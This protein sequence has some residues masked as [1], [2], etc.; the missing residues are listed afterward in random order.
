[1]SRQSLIF[2]RALNNTILS[3]DDIARRAPAVFADSK[4]QRLTS[5]YQSLRTDT[6]LPILADYGYQPTQAA[7]KR[8]RKIAGLD[9]HSAHLLA[10][11]KTS[12]IYTND[13]IR[14]EIVLY[15]SH[16]GT[17]SV[18]LYAGAYRFICSNGIVAGDGFS[19]TAYHSRKALSGFEEMLRGVIANMPKLLD[20]IDTMRQQSLDYD[21]RYALA[22]QAVMKRWQLLDDAAVEA[23]QRGGNVKRGSYADNHTINDVLGMQRAE[24]AG[25][26][27]WTTFNRIQENVL[28]G[29][30]F[31]RSVVGDDNE[32]VVRQ[33]KARPIT[34]ISE[35]V[36]INSELWDIA[37]E[38]ATA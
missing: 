2:S 8:S 6:L 1:M 28:R 25:I 17:S 18:K 16:N 23:M 36:R 34:N 33:R 11:S 22:K 26:D 19:A 29:N 9:Q 32:V 24:D 13:D 4:A 3:A 7:Q 15:N 12:D 31:V 35:H 20:R 21:A 5:R 14:P 38:L 10:F 30:A 27:A 37:S